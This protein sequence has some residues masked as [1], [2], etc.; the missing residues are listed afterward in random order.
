MA[1]LNMHMTPEFADDLDRFM[2]ARKLANK[3][4]AIRLAVREGLERA[5]DEAGCTDFRSL[6]GAATRAPVAAR[7]RFTSH[8]QLWDEP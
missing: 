3:S 1:Q 6:I 7:P 5:L 4:E 2:R 8:D